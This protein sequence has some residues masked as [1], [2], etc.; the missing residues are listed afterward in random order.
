MINDPDGSLGAGRQ[1]LHKQV[2]RKKSK[3][4][5]SRGTIA[6][7]KEL[8]RMQGTLVDEV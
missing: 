7:Q 2:W 4:E 3:E 1:K 5:P 6:K 8:E